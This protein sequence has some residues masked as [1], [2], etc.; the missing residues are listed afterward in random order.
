[1]NIFFKP[2]IILLRSMILRL[3]LSSF[4][5]LSTYYLLPSSK[6]IFVV[7]VVVL[8]SSVSVLLHYT[9]LLVAWILLWLLLSSRVAVTPAAQGYILLVLW[10]FALWLV[11]RKKEVLVV[12]TSEYPVLFNGMNMIVYIVSIALMFSCCFRSTSLFYGGYGVLLFLYARVLQ[13][14]SLKF[15]VKKYLL[16]GL[17]V[18]L[19][20]LV[21]EVGAFLFVSPELG[22]FE[23]DPE[24]LFRLRPRGSFEGI[25]TDNSGNIVRWNMTSSSLG[26]R[27]RENGEKKENEYRIVTL[28]D[29]FT[30][31]QALQEEDTFQRE[32]E[33]LLRVN[34]CN[35]EVHVI[36]CGIGA[37]APWQERLLL[38]KV[39]FSLD[40]DL[41]VL[42][43]FPANDIEGDY[44]EINRFLPC[45]NREMMRQGMSFRNYDRLPFLLDRLVWR[46]SLIYRKW[47]QVTK[48]RGF[49]SDV[50]A[51]LRFLPFADC[52]M[53]VPAVDR[54]PL[55]EPCLRDWYPELEEAW[56]LY[57]NS[58]RGIQEDCQAYGIPLVAFVHGMNISLTPEFWETSNKDHPNTPYEMNKDVR[59]TQELFA[60]FGIPYVDITSAFMAQP[61]RENLFY[62]HEGH[63][64]PEGAKVLASTLA[65][66]LL[67]NFLETE[68]N[69][70]QKDQAV[71][72]I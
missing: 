37:Y 50:L 32:L 25:Y 2:Y 15:I 56:A 14:L 6:Y 62:I 33:R 45:F 1:M 35:K 29:S 59:L 47:C 71:E 17:F 58:I 48:R 3:L 16:L 30:M 42:Q 28:G 13:S 27:D 12:R 31:G 46:Y 54:D 39:G 23:Y 8:F 5:L 69:C 38:Q 22:W 24:L 44:L 40:P 67:N 64:S 4:L 43:L 60:E 34:N 63:F 11:Y 52:K 55:L 57:A 19:P 36:N 18:A 10:C 21:F 61:H 26:I 72:E 66:F 41:V 20:F 65:D 70:N 9:V 7:L 68:L 49:V 53:P 51:D